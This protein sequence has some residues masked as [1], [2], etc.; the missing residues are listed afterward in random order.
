[1]GIVTDVV[2]EAKAALEGVTEGPWKL[3]EPDGNWIWPH[4]CNTYG[5]RHEDAVFIAAA[6]S[7]IPALVAEV[8]R[9]REEIAPPF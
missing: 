8:E 6:R 1:V 3:S 2:A 4:V 5:S 7:L 9:L